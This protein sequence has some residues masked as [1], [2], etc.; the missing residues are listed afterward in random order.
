ME[1]IGM[2]IRVIAVA[3]IVA[4]LVVPGNIAGKTNT[5][6]ER[7]LIELRLASWA[8]AS[9][10]VLVEAEQVEGPLCLHEEP[11]ISDQHIS[12]VSVIRGRKAGIAISLEF[13][14]EGSLR[15]A[16]A[17][18]DNIGSHIALLLNSEPVHVSTIQSEFPSELGRTTV[19]AP[20]MARNIARQIDQMIT[21]RFRPIEGTFRMRND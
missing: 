16:Q 11:V 12:G 18:R 3:G 1:R 17:T 14:E 7:Y 2:V 19:G 4:G 6:Q 9:G 10:Y 8:P 15:L 20:R 13:T 21:A 5:H